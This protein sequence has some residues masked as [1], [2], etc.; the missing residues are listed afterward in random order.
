MRL[1]PGTCLKKADLD[2]LEWWGAMASLLIAALLTVS[3]GFLAWITATNH[4]SMVGVNC[5]LATMVIAWSLVIALLTTWAVMRFVRRHLGKQRKRIDE[6]IDRLERIVLD[7]MERLGEQVGERLD[8][9][10]EQV[11]HAAISRW[12]EA[13]NQPYEQDYTHRPRLVRG[14]DG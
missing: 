1:R 12:L 3:V 10:G 9:L 6:R 2:S 8:E 7:R 4:L 11:N 14:N 13:A 5:M